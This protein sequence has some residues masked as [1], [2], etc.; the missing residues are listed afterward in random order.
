[1]KKTIVL[2]GIMAFHFAAQAA[3]VDPDKTYRALQLQPRF[4][5]AT[6]VANVTKLVY[7]F[8]DD[9][10]IWTGAK[11]TWLELLKL[12]EAN[13]IR[14]FV[15]ADRP[16]EGAQ[17]FLLGDADHAAWRSLIAPGVTTVQSV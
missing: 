11:K 5:A 8:S 4:P 1:M 2:C 16:H 9:A 3:P 14:S 10:L 7:M 15:F 12:P 6:G 17:F 13:R